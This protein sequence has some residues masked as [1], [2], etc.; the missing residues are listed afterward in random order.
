MVETL[1]EKIE[2]AERK[3]IRTKFKYEVYAT[4]IRHAYEQIKEVD[5]ESIPLLGDLIETMERIRNLDIELKTYILDNIHEVAS[6][7]ETSYE[8]RREKIIQNLRRGLEILKNKEGL[9]KMNELYSLALAGK[10]F[11]RDFDEHLEEIR[12]RAY[13]LDEETQKRYARQ[14]VAY[15]Y[16]K[17]F[18]KGLLID[19]TK[20]EPLYK[21]FIETDDLGEFVLNLPEYI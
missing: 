12:D 1:D 2:E 4:A 21:Q 20:Y 8:Y 17:V 11:L 7:A 3:I 6:D 9:L 14:E 18:V 15:D 16:L 5:Q 13:D 19:P 10:I